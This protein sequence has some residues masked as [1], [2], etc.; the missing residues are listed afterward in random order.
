MFIST[1]ELI[2]LLKVEAGERKAGNQALLAEKL[3]VSESYLSCVMTGRMSIGPKIYRGMGF[4]REM[5]FRKV[6]AK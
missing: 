1:E 2:N 4:E 3:G 5:V 6:K